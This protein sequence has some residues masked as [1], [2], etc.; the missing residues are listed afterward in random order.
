M[1]IRVTLM[2]VFKKN[3]PEGDCL[4]LS[5]NATIRNALHE[6]DLPIE[7]VHAV[8]VNGQFDRDLDRQLSPDDALTILAPVGGG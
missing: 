5:D 1:Q 3:T 6:L 7:R 4:T 2:G 8:L